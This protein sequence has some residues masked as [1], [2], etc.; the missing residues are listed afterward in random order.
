MTSIPQNIQLHPLQ[1][2]ILMTT[3]VKDFIDATEALIAENDEI[4]NNNNAAAEADNDNMNDGNDNEKVI[5]SLRTTTTRDI[6][7]AKA[8]E[9]FTSIKK[10]P[11]PQRFRSEEEEEEADLD[12]HNKL[13][14]TVIRLVFLFLLEAANE[15]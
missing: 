13:V 11:H 8:K 14:L 15:Q 1:T 12:D 2:A 6:I 5:S 7:V 10:S 9:L 3:S 4:E